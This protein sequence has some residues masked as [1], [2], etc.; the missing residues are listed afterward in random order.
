MNDHLI[1]LVNQYSKNKLMIT[2]YSE[3][4][5]KILSELFINLMVDKF[6][7]YVSLLRRK[8]LGKMLRQKEVKHCGNLC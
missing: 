8:L 2:S 1:K 4:I 3:K 6:S 5:Y 7:R